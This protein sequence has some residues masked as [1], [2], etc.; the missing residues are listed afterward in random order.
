MNEVTSE[1]SMPVGEE[2]LK[3]M[4]D[5]NVFIR[6]RILRQF[7]I[8]LHKRGVASVDDLF[9]ESRKQANRKSLQQ[10][11]EENP[12]AGPSQGLPFLLKKGSQPWPY[13]N[14]L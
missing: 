7:L 2:N 11:D 1:S 8:E 14:A 13:P 12:K 6:E 5:E 9:D 4:I 3:A 10:A